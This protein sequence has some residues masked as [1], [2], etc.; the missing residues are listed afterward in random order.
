MRQN[1]QHC[2]AHTKKHFFHEELRG[3]EVN[4]DFDE[5]EDFEEEEDYEEDTDE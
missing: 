4:E 2:R 1:K 3:W 5:E